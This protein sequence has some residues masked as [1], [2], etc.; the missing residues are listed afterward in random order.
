MLIKNP[1]YCHW[2]T[3][4]LYKPLAIHEVPYASKILPSFLCYPIAVSF[5]CQ[6]S[7]SRPSVNWPKQQ[8]VLV[9]GSL[10]TYL[11]LPHA[12]IQHSLFGDLS[13]FTKAAL[14]TDPLYSNESKRQNPSRAHQET[15]CGQGWKTS[16]SV[17][18]SIWTKFWVCSESPATCNE[19]AEQCLLKH[20]NMEKGNKDAKILQ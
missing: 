20:L 10:R 7:W 11:Q 4:Y 13:L 15:A 14:I 12:L 3:F 1:C 9:V 18:D 17:P 5:Y 16:S 6:G 8:W 2:H 19:T